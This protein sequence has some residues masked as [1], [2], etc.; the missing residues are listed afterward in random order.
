[1]VQIEWMLHHVDLMMVHLSC[2]S[3]SVGQW[4]WCVRLDWMLGGWFIDCNGG[5]VCHVGSC[6]LV[7]CGGL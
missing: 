3:R 5:V 7:W 1:M 6:E 4:P 2:V